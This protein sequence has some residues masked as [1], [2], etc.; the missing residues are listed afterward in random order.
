MAPRVLLPP[1]GSKKMDVFHHRCVQR[2][3]LRS[4]HCWHASFIVGGTEFGERLSGAKDQWLFPGSLNRWDTIFTPPIG[5][6]NT[7]Y[8]P[9]IVLANWVIIWYRSHLLREPGNSIEKI[10]GNFTFFK[11]FWGI[12]K[13]LRY[14][15]MAILVGGLCSLLYETKK[16]LRKWTEWLLSIPHVYYPIWSMY[17]ILYTYAFTI[18]INQI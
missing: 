18:Q 15:T 3:Q 12:M 6:K 2:R 5:R 17:S 8:I 11:L 16:C 4:Q 1:N 14:E 13:S 9:L 7:T 10:G